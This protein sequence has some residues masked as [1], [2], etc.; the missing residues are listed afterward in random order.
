MVL[1]VF[2]GN[3]RYWLFEKGKE[4]FNMSRLSFLFQ[5]KSAHHTQLL[6]QRHFSWAFRCHCYSV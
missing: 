5:W 4:L 6:I 3:K 1:S 2:E